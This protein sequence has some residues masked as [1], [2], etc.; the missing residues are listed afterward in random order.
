M[1]RN[2]FNLLASKNNFGK[3]FVCLK[4][5]AFFSS[6]YFNSIYCF[7]DAAILL[8][9]FLYENKF[10]HI[11]GD[12]ASLLFPES[13]YKYDSA[14]HAPYYLDALNLNSTAW[15]LPVTCSCIPLFKT[16]S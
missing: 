14:E 6:V 15:Y 3:T 8:E 11:W 5:S 2:V 13:L 10:G 1:N 7:S 12:V 16:F 4:N 9:T